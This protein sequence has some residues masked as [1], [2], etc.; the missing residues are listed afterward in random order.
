MPFSIDE[1]LKVP[2][3]GILRNYPSET[4]H[5]I[6]QAYMDAGMT[7]IEVTMNT[8]GAESIIASLCREF[9]ELNIGAGTVCTLRQLND[10]L[11]AGAQYI[12]T[13]I[14]DEAVIKESVKLNIPIFPGAYTPTEIY[15][16]WS[17][18]ATAVKVFPAGQ[19][20]VKYIKDVSAPLNEIKLMAVGGVNFENIKTFFDAGVYGVGMGSAL[21]NKD[22]IETN[23]FEGLRDYFVQIR[24]SLLKL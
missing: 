19:L 6:A 8:P 23:D 13:P 3:I 24:K 10:A 11:I 17:W 5:H 15:K 14:L 2:I 22:L 1:F 21:F 16:S 7:T 4:I 18:G 12:V 9:P 20:G